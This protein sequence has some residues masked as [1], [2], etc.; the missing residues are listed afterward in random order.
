MLKE[1][2]PI[3]VD[4]DNTV[5]EKL[6]IKNPSGFAII[7]RADNVTIKECDLEGGIYLQGK[8]KNVKV[9]NNYIHDMKPEGD[10]LTIKQ[11]AGV[12]TSEGEGVFAQYGLG[13]QG[14]LVKGN[15]FKNVT[16]GVFIVGSSD[17]IEVNG[18]YCENQYGPFPRGQMC[19]VYK[20]KT[21][22]DT[23]IKIINNFSYIDSELPIQKSF[24]TN[25]RIGGE[26]H[27]NCNNTWGCKESPVL[28]EGNFIY[29]GS[30]SNSN[31]GIMAADGGG[32]YYHILNNKVYYSENCG[33][34]ICG[35]TGNVIK[36]NR[37]YQSKSMAL[38]ERKEGRGI[39]IECYGSPFY[40]ET[41][42]EDNLVAFKS[43]N[44]SYNM[45]NLLCRTDTAVFKNNKFCTDK[46]F[47]ELDPI[48]KHEPPAADNNLIKPWELIEKPEFTT[49]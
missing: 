17:N 22:A 32:E 30:G 35:G 10:T 7:V 46:E 19:Q 13:V 14:V 49:M 8:I 9:L 21:S 18:N 48:P 33:I 27:I 23:Y 24:N 42:V 12:T 29:G 15:F 41:L 39:Q 4:T 11:T 5:V 40:G 44:W 28:I 3:I 37:I 26:D 43:S 38:K 16:T 25:G 45:C 34:G 47:G 1:S 6:K 31:S 36:G 2:K 20:C